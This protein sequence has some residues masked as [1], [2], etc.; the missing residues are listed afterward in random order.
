MVWRAVEV[1]W[2]FVLHGLDCR[3]SAMITSPVAP[4]ALE[5]MR[6]AMISCN[7]LI[8]DTMFSFWCRNLDSSGRLAKIEVHRSTAGSASRLLETAKFLSKVGFD[9]ELR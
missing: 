1:S 5:L 8:H 4:R 7:A 9:L 2:L 6:V 3:P